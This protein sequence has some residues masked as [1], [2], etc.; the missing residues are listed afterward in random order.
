MAQH[1]IEEGEGRMTKDELMHL[2]GKKITVYFKHKESA[3]YG[4]LKY[5]DDFSAKHDYRKPGYFYIN[6]TSFKVSHIR[7]VEPKQEF[8]FDKIRAEIDKQEKWLLQ[9]GY[10]AYNVDI[11]L[12]AIKAAVVERDSKE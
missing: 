5:A 11:A 1:F 3:I 2:V 8:I 6:H 12:D 10:T 9:A 4:E 7:K